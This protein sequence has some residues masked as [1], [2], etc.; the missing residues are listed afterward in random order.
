METNLRAYKRSNL[1]TQTNQGHYK[2]SPN[3]GSE[4]GG[5]KTP[6]A[7]LLREYKCPWE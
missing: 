2:A 3:R 7:T 5:L 4:C 6:L 1:K